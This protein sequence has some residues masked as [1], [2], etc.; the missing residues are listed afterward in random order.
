MDDT[1]LI[2]YRC[3]RCSAVFIGA[4]SGAEHYEM[5][6]SADDGHPTSTGETCNGDVVEIKKRPAVTRGD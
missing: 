4:P 5:I 2:L 6:A 1:P 3:Q